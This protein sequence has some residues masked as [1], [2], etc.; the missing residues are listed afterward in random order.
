MLTL[1]QSREPGSLKAEAFR[2]AELDTDEFATLLG[3]LS[4][5]EHEV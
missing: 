1:G 4:A 5:A 3:Q 2:E